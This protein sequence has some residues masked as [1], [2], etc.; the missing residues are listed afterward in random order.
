M[1][2]L[3]GCDSHD[4]VTIPLDHSNCFRD[5]YLVNVTRAGIVEWNGQKLDDA[6][7]KTYLQQY[8]AL[9]KGAG[10]LWVEFEPGVSS[11]RTDKVREQIIMSGL[12]E[13]MRCVEG[14]WGVKRPVVY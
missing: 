4:A 9:P 1:L 14:V 7:F 3:C 8:A 13:Q 10:R 11:T 2:T 5:G 6:Q 12:C